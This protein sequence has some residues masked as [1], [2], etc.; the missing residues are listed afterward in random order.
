MDDKILIWTNPPKSG[1]CDR[2][3]DFS[4]MATFAKLNN[5]KFNSKLSK[6]IEDLLDHY[7]TFDNM[8]PDVKFQ[9]Q[10][11]KKLAELRQ[12]DPFIYR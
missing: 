7:K 2:L 9:I 5:S 10:L 11:K 12:R 6:K 8:H 4:L 1:L 3:I